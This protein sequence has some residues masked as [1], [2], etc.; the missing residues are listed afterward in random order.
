MTPPQVPRVDPGFDTHGKPG[1]QS[2]PVVHA[3]PAPTQMPPQMNV[4]VEDCP[5][6]AG[7]GTHASPQQ[8]ALVAQA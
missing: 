3:P 1:Q 7:L 2:A 8:S 4:G 5:V 6:N